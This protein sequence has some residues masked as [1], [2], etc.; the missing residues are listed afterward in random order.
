VETSLLEWT[1]PS[2]RVWKFKSNVFYVFIGEEMECVVRVLYGAGV[3]T[4]L[5]ECF[6]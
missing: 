2:L 1:V 6:I 3:D 5:F 4:V